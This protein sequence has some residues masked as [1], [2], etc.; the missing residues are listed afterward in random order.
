MFKKYFGIW[1]MI[2]KN[3]KNSDDVG[4]CCM[5]YKERSQILT[6]FL[7]NFKN[8]HELKEFG[9][10]KI[11]DSKTFVDLKNVPELYLRPWFF[12]EF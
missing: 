4:K 2:I 9:D 3:H 10:K 1:N 5:K 11:T 12:S 8:I 7:W 6:I